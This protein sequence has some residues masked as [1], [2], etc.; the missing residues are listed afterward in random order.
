MLSPLLF[1]IYAEAKLKEAMEE[2]CEGVKVGGYLV[3]AIRFADYQAMTASTERGLQNK[4]LGN[5]LTEDG[6]SDREV[7]TSIAIRS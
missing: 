1:N 3:Q 4:Y 5:V 7:K 2:V 6:R